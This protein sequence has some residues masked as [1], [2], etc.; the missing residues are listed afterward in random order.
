MTTKNFSK[1]D[2]KY[3]LTEE[4]MAFASFNELPIKNI[5][6]GVTNPDPNYKISRKNSPQYTFEYVVKGQGE[7]I[8]PNEKFQLKEGD[9]Y[10]ILQGDSVTYRSSQTNPMK[11]YWINFDCD[12]LKTMLRSYKITTGVYKV[13]TLTAFENLILTSKSDKSFYEIYTTISECI[14]S[15]I[16]SISLHQN[17][18]NEGYS[19]KI[20]EVLLKAVYN[21][22][23]L[24]DIA[25][26]V[27]MS[28]SNLIRTFKKRFNETPFEFIIKSKI[29]AS[30]LLLTSTDMTVKEIAE[31]FNFTDAHYFSSTFKKYTGLRPSEYKKQYSALSR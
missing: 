11:K 8:T 13:D 10:V 17:A 31:R 21:K 16:V 24:K 9:T 1:Y 2:V 7:L 29:D 15:I 14:N 22:L 26:E 28:E 5:A 6:V 12:Y 27:G 3:P 20:K 4:A 18:V 19:N 23:S 25:N 30:K